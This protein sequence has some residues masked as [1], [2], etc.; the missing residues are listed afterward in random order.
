MTHATAWMALK[1]LRYAKR[2]CHKQQRQQH[3]TTNTGWFRSREAPGVVG[4]LVTGR[5]T[6]GA[7]WAVG[8]QGREWGAVVSRRRSFRLARGKRSGALPFKW[9]TLNT[10]EPCTWRWWRWRIPCCVCPLTAIES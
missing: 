6:V 4:L 10:T 5:R 1:T 7:V 3:T 9:I 8:L 2:A